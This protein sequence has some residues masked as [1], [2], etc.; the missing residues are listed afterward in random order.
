MRLTWLVAAVETR[1]VSTRGLYVCGLLAAILVLGL[2]A[3]ASRSFATGVLP[4]K[5][6]EHHA[7]SQHSI[8]DG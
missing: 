5:Q 3:S 1:R 2:S 7:S 6:Y 8:A 4:V